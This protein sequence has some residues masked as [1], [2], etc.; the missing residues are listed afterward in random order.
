M[1]TLSVHPD[2]DLIAAK[3]I[4]G[5]MLEEELEWIRDVARCF[6]VIIEI[7]IWKGRSTKVWAAYTSGTVIAI[8]HFLGSTK[9]DDGI[10]HEAFKTLGGQSRLINSAIG[11]LSKELG[12]GKLFIIPL[13]SEL[14]YR[15]VMELLFGMK[16]DVLFIDGDHYS[17]PRDLSLYSTLVKEDGLICGHDRGHD[18]VRAAINQ[19]NYKEGTG[20]IWYTKKSEMKKS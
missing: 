5:W 2:L 19:I 16:A 1:T 8:D 20:S 15:N 18:G 9:G 17:T 13:P 3:A 4:D 6:N 12:A 10:V 14:A 7:G 11:N